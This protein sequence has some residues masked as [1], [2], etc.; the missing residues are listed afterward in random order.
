MIKLNRVTEADHKKKLTAKG[1]KVHKEK[2]CN[3]GPS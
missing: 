3:R 2:P 1:M